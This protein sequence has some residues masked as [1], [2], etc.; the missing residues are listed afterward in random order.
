LLFPLAPNG[1]FLYTPLRGLFVPS[2]LRVRPV[3]LT[4][5]YFE[6][7]VNS[8]ILNSALKAAQTKT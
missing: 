2:R 1:V 7:A 3:S 8:G 5:E 6:S 4:I